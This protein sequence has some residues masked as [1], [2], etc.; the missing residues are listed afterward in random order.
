MNRL[1]AL[2]GDPRNVAGLTGAAAGLGLTFGGVIDSGWW[3]ITAGLYAAGFL[4][5]QIGLPARAPDL[6]AL[7]VADLPDGLRRLARKLAPALPPA[8]SAHLDNILSAVDAIEPRL[9]EADPVALSMIPVRQI[10]GDYIPTTLTTYAALPARVRTRSRAGDGR[11]PEAQVTEQLG[12]LE[13]QMDQLVDNLSR[14]DLTAL[15]TQGRFLDTKF[16]AVD[17][18]SAAA[19]RQAGG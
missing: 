18:W 14:G 1:L 9:R 13:Q 7:S 6:A 8:A 4:A 3:A 16:R 2:I 15:E 17:S 5:M 19:E 12:L 11:T 10:M